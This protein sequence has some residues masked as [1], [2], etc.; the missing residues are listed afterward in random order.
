MPPEDNYQDEDPHIECAKYI[1]EL[2]QDRDRLR[3]SVEEATELYMEEVDE[4]KRLQQENER[5]REALRDYGK[6]T[7]ICDD[8]N[9]YQKPKICTCGFAEALA[10]D[11]CEICGSPGDGPH[12]G[13]KHAADRD[14][15]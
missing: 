13:D 9:F 10:A 5:L 2:K 3:A 4:N 1:S 14:D 7:T 6:H 11:L 15:K 8:L 12:D